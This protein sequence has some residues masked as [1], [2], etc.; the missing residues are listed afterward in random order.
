[1]PTP[2]INLEWIIDAYNNYPE[3]ENFFTAY[4]DVLAGGPVLREQ[5]QRGM[6]EEQIHASWRAQ[7][8]KFSQIRKKYL[9]L[10]AD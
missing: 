3:K 8:E 10:L 2:R 9:L 7:L 6:T 1:M 4:F 5:I